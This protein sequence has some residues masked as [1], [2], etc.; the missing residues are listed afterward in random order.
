M[1]SKQASKTPQ[2]QGE[3]D[4]D[5]MELLAVPYNKQHCKAKEHVS[6]MEQS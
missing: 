5:N 2:K 4:D 1:L 6:K 3:Y